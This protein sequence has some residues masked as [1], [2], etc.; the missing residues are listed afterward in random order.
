MLV[1]RGAKQLSVD[2]DAV[3]LTNDRSVD[4][5]I[6]PERSGDFR[7]RELRIPEAHDGRTRDDAKIV[8]SGESS[9]EGFR[10]T[11]CKIVLRWVA[12]QILEWKHCQR[13]DSGR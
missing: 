5:G 11:V 9:D 6:H 8:N 1:G 10:H 3:A 7:R 4:K 2:A 12:G 13:F